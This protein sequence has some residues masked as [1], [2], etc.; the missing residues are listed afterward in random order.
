MDFYY[1]NIRNLLKKL[2]NFLSKRLSFFVAQD[3]GASLNS[4]LKG[5]YIF[6]M[7]D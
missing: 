1:C 7:N 5:C 6:D 4:L 3:L 2:F